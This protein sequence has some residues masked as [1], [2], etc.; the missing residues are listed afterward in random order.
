M[1]GKLKGRTAL[2]HVY[3]LA[4]LDMFEEAAFSALSIV[5]IGLAPVLIL[6]S[7]LEKSGQE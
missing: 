1:P 6:H 2:P 3:T 4:S 5:A 7:T